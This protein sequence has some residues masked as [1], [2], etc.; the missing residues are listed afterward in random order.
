MTGIQLWDKLQAAQAKVVARVRSTI[1]VVAASGLAFAEQVGSALGSDIAA[2]HLWA[3][4]VKVVSV[5]CIGLS[6]L[7]RA[8]EKNDEPP[9]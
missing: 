9:K 3:T 5:I 4:R 2:A 8:G 6:F 1:A 7:L